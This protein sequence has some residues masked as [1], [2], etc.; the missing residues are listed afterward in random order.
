MQL[1][2]YTIALTLACIGLIFC[3]DN[4]CILCHNIKNRGKEAPIPYYPFVGSLFLMVAISMVLPPHLA[5]W[6]YIALVIDY[7]C[8]PMCLHWCFKRRATT[9]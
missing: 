4:W 7:G 1:I 9:R 2:F 6:G 5:L 8:L 3:I